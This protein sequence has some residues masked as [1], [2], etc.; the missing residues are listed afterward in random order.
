[1]KLIEIIP[2][3]AIIHELKST[4]K[5][6]A[7]TELVQVMKKAHSGERFSISGLVDAI[8]KREKLGTTGMGGGVA[9]PHAKLDGIKGIIGAFGRSSAGLDFNAVDGEAVH[10]VFLILSSSSKA[11]PH[12]N[13]L[14]KVMSAIRQPN[15]LKFLRSAKK[16]R[17][18]EDVFKEVEE[19]APV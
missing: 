4:D 9:V 7:I 1:M 8:L 13:A 3:K 16:T 14:R 5:K 2:R 6:S 19:V 10:V 12:L 18:I 15:V 11:E 17:D